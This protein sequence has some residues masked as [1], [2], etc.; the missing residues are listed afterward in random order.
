MKER[1]SVMTENELKNLIRSNPD[2]GFRQLFEQYHGYAFT[3]IHRTLGGTGCAKDAE[4]C[5]VDTFADVILHYDTYAKGSLRSYIGAVARNKAI[6]LK[7][8]LTTAEFYT[9]GDEETN[10]IP[11][12]SDSIEESA[13]K[14]QTFRLL[15]DKVEGLG[16]PD[17][18]IIIHKFFFDMSSIE[19][20]KTVGMTPAAVR[21]RLS[22]SLKKLKK[23]LEELGVTL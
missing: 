6:N 18:T 11:D 10:D 21:M 23:S 5:I 16:K 8:S 22:R 20:A 9:V 4:D 17:S 13:E 15:L 19:I 3:I 14:S 1:M 2:D 7:R 12:N